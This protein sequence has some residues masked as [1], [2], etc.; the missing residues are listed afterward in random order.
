MK[1]TENVQTQ[2]HAITASANQGQDALLLNAELDGVRRQLA[3]EKAR[4][5]AAEQLAHKY[6]R[7]QQLAATTHEEQMIAEK[8][9]YTLL[10]QE[11][12][13]ICRQYEK[14]R[15]KESRPACKPA[16][17]KLNLSF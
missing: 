7:D 5:D 16:S 12:A 10:Q 11:H 8:K 17:C 1:G 4:A 15:A 14:M 3:E 13:L 6:Q 9:R 2:R